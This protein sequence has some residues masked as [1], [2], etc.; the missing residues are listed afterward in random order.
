VIEELR[1]LERGG[2]PGLV[3]E[4]IKLFLK[5]AESQF[6]QLKEAQTRRDSCLLERSAHTLKGSSGNLG[7]L[8]MSRI[9][10]EL[11]TVAEKG[12]WSQAAVLLP[13]LEAEF[14]AVRLE[15]E[16]ERIRP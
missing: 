12:D 5:E 14:R 6:I 7:A 1:A 11:Q 15:L 4:L 10:A 2:A 9:C 8:T 3:Q 16:A 13:E